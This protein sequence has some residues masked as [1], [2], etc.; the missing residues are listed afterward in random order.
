MPFIAP[1]CSSLLMITSPFAG[2]HSVYAD[3]SWQWLFEPVRAYLERV[4]PKYVTL[5]APA[6]G[7]RTLVSVRSPQRTLAVPR[8]P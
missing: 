2:C 6:W 1:V 7:V 3:N 4:S 5:L 8:A